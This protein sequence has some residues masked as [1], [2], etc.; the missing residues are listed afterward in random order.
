MSRKRCRRKVYQLV[1]PIAH[2][3]ESIR[4]VSDE[5]S[6][7]LRMLELQAVDAFAKGHAV[8][9]DWRVIADMSNI[10][11]T[12][13]M[14]GIGPEVLAV[15]KRAEHAL[16]EAHRRQRE[17]GR[18]GMTGPELQAIRDLHAFHDLQ[19]QSITFG[20]YEKAIER[21]RDRIV[22]AHPSLKVYV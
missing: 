1:N 2:V 18:L 13:A 21:T 10:A 19:R 4:V 20:E 7:A 6:Q 3:L 17:Y 11:T 8:K 16:G 14:D 5:K 12:L 9:S 15:I 22:S